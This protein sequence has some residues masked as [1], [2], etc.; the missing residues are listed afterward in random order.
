LTKRRFD[1]K[2]RCQPYDGK[3]HAAEWI[4]HQ[5]SVVSK[6]DLSWTV[7]DHEP[8]IEMNLAKP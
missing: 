3:G 8:H 2:Y 4:K 7:V 1:E 6:T 5:P